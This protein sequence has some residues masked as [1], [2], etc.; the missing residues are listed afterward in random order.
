M[1]AMAS[2]QFKTPEK[3]TAGT[4]DFFWKTFSQRNWN[5]EQEPNFVLSSEMKNQYMDTKGK[6]EKQYKARELHFMHSLSKFEVALTN[7]DSKESKQY[8]ITCNAIQYAILSLF[9]AKEQMTYLQVEQALDCGSSHLVTEAMKKLC[10]PVS[11]VLKKEVKKPVFT[12][13]E[14]ITLKKDY[15]NKLI[16]ADF[17]PPR[18]QPDIQKVVS[19]VNQDVQ[20]SRIQVTK[21]IIVKQMK[22][23]AQNG[24]SLGYKELYAMI[25]PLIKVFRLN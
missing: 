15:K 6:Y 7:A 13:N 4:Y 23:N 17:R 2:E 25:E 8:R 11:G 3:Q 21:A 20:R 10:H 1:T 12:P 14:K 19:S 22:A 5:T 16:K 18:P 24:K 9:N